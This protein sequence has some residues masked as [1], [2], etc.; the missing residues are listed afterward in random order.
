MKTT[1]LPES[2]CPYCGQRFDAATAADP[3]KSDAVPEPGDITVCIGCAS[4][5]V[6]NKNLT[7]SVPGRREINV[8]EEI[9]IAQRAVRMLDRRK[10]NDG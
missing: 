3:N 5:L 4:I 7:V 9:R 10:K 2:L 1:R 8:T 6:F